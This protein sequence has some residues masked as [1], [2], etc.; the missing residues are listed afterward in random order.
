MNQHNPPPLCRAEW[1]G[2][3]W[4]FVYLACWR[5][6]VLQGLSR[7][8]GGLEVGM[9]VWARLPLPLLGIQE[10]LPRKVTCS[11]PMPSS[12]FS[13][14]LLC[15]HGFMGGTKTSTGDI[16][17]PLD[18]GRKRRCLSTLECRSGVKIR[19]KGMRGKMGVI[20]PP[21]HPLFDWLRTQ[22]R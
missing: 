20:V 8:I 21:L 11:M 14:A 6:P 4:E 16:P 5:F 12:W 17:L 3:L 15:L 22:K 10:S 9:C 2:P 19:R 18:T 1:T 13:Q 7:S